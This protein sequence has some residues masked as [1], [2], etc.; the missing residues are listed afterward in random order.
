MNNFF[1]QLYEKCLTRKNKKLEEEIQ[2]KLEKTRNL[3]KLRRLQK[4]KKQL[5][6]IRSDKSPE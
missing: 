3:E 5:D 6:K 2:N 4:K 1:K